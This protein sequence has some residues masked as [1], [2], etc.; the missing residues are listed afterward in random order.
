MK[1]LKFKLKSTILLGV[2]LALFNF[3]LGC[4]KR[5]LHMNIFPAAMLTFL[6]L[7]QYYPSMYSQVIASNGKCTVLMGS[8]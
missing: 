8:M 7:Q 3:T 2:F 6:V 1:Y 4:V 5:S